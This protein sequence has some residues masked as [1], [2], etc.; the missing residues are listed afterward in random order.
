MNNNKLQILVLGGRGF[1]GKAACHELRDHDVFTFGRGA[2]KN[3][4]QGNILSLNDLKAAIANKDYL[5]NLV[6]LSPLKKPTS[7]TYEEIHVLGVK[8]LLLACKDAKLRKLIHISALG[9]NKA[10]DIE[11]LKTKGIS[12]DLIL[13]SDIS[14]TIFCPSFIFDK[15]NELIKYSS[16]FAYGIMFP[17][18]PAKIQ[19]IFRGDMAKL[20]SLAIE[21]IIT[22]KRIEVAGPEVMTVFSLASKVFNKKGMPCIPISLYFLIPGMRIAAFFN[23]FGLSE[24]QIRMLYTDSITDSNGAGKYIS[25]TRFDDWLKNAPI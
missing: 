14:A 1:L 20:V 23:M 22:E 17:D 6:G 5:I 24:D 4:V 3:H 9:A 8:N 21:G 12:E 16:K 7:A 2:E 15:D 13:E 10:S 25:L 18:I 11:Y 19:P